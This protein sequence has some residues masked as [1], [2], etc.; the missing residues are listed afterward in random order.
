MNPDKISINRHQSQAN[1]PFPPPHL[2]ALI[3][4]P[5]LTDVSPNLIYSTD[6]EDPSMLIWSRATQLTDIKSLPE[7]S[8]RRRDRLIY[9]LSTKKVDL[10]NTVNRRQGFQTQCLGSSGAV[11]NIGYCCSSFL[12]NARW[13][14]FSLLS[15]KDCLSVFSR[16]FMVMWLMLSNNVKLTIT[17]CFY[18][19]HVRTP[20]NPY[21]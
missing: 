6:V 9:L 19:F 7:S 12:R 17:R 2:S 16:L 20:I 8:N 14:L 13:K 4:Q 3:L 11:I 21:D 10:S 5:I 15:L 1:N 18:P